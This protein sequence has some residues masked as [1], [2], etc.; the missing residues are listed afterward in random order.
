MHDEPVLA[1]PPLA[2]YRLSKFVRRHKA[3]LRITAAAALVLLLAFGGVTW[4]LWDRA[5]R[6]AELSTRM[7]QT[8]QTV[9]AALIKTD[10]WHKQ[11]G[12][13]PSATSEEAD[14]ALALWRQA[15]ASLAQAETALKTGTADDRLRQRVLNVQQQTEQQLAQARRTA[16]LFHGLDEARMTRSIWTGTH[17]DFAGSATKYA[18]AFAAYGLEVTPGRTEEL[19]RRIRAE[20]P[21]IR[22]AL[23]VALHS[24]RENADSAKNAELAKLVGAIAAAAVDDQ[25]RRQYRACN[26]A[27]DRTA[28]RELSGQARRLSLAPSSLELLAE[29]LDSQGN[30]DEA[31]DLLRWARGRYPADFEIHFEL[32]NLLYRN[33]NLLYFYC[34]LRLTGSNC[35]G[36]IPFRHGGSRGGEMSWNGDSKHGWMK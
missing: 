27:S 4:A 23:I 31:V 14:A 24:W 22:E 3:G 29:K 19:A 36:S 13:A 5:A 8:E 26:T 21:A 18:A 10:Q 15:E 30:R 2:W 28:L 9:N 12:E 16:D 20:R 25:W 7:A 6:R 11:A 17:F 1:C 34:I 35:C 33:G 32:G